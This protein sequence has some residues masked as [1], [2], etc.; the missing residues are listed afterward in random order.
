LK[1]GGAL[2]VLAGDARIEKRCVP[3]PHCAQLALLDAGFVLKEE[4][5][6]I[7]HEGYQG[8]VVKERGFLLIYHEKLFIME[9]P[10][11][12]PPKYSTVYRADTTAGETYKN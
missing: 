7:Q 1:P 4:A 10:T 6:K 8:G 9:K 2:G 3:A 11:G 12:A 5:I